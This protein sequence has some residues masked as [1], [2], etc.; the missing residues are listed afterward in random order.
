MCFVV[1]S[2]AVDN[3]QVIIH[4]YIGLDNCNKSAWVSTGH[5]VHTL[6]FIIRNARIPDGVVD[7]IPRK[8]A[9]RRIG[10]QLLDSFIH[11]KLQPSGRITGVFAIRASGRVRVTRLISLSI[12]SV[13][14]ETLHRVLD[15]MALT[16]SI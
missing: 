10:N 4:V 14:L 11:A 6:A 8:D 2:S 15:I 3:I 1:S 5:I 13:Q 9:K 16:C 12:R 7:N